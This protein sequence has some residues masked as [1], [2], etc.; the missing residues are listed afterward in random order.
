MKETI[1]NTDTEISSTAVYIVQQTAQLLHWRN[2][3]YKKITY[4]DITAQIILNLDCVGKIQQ[5]VF[6]E[7]A[8]WKHGGIPFIEQLYDEIHKTNISQITDTIN[9]ESIGEFT[10]AISCMRQ[11]RKSLTKEFFVNY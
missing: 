9:K 1:T 5:M 7:T 6:D 10:E 4:D 2:N 11:L 8:Q 3:M